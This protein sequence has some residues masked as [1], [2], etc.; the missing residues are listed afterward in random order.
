M[1]IRDYDHWNEEAERVW[2]EEVGKHE[3]PDA[4]M[5]KEDYLEMMYQ[6]WYEED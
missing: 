5:S 2:W 1:T 6:D 4:G 3:E